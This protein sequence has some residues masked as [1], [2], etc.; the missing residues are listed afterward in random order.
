MKGEWA[1]RLIGH[2]SVL[3]YA[4]MAAFGFLEI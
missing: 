3:N 2:T 1:S 4:G